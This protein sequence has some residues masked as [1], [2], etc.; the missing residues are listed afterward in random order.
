MSINECILLQLQFLMSTEEQNHKTQL[1]A[2]SEQFPHLYC[3]QLNRK[4]Y[5]LPNAG[6]L[7]RACSEAGTLQALEI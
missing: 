7:D 3:L 6:A 2:S 5:L 4:Q 1:P